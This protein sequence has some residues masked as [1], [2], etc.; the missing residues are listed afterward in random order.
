MLNKVHVLYSFLQ[1]LQRIL[2]RAPRIKLKINCSFWGW[3]TVFQLISFP[4][5]FGFCLYWDFLLARHT[6]NEEHQQA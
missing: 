1:S 4:A 3:T 6:I 2:V 5:V